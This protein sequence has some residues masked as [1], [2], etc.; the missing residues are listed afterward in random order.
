MSCATGGKLPREVQTICY[1][2][3]HLKNNISSWEI[4]EFSWRREHVSYFGKQGPEI[5]E[6]SK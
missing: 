1:R 6:R 2:D 4:K 5:K 3:S